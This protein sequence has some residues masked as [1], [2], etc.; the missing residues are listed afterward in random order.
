VLLRTSFHSLLIRL[1]HRLDARVKCWQ[2]GLQGM[3][4]SSEQMDES[5]ARLSE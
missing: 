3:R 5:F 4:V 2:L 1:S